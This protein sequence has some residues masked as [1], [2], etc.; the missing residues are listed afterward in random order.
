MRKLLMCLGLLA[1][2]APALAQRSTIQIENPWSRATPGQS[3]TGAAY[4][5]LHNTGAAPDKL[6]SA[7]SPVAAKVELHNHVMSGNVAQMRPVDAIE[8]A[9]GSPTVLQPGGLHVMLIDLKEP[10]KAGQKFPVTLTFEKAGAISVEVAVQALRP[11]PSHSHGAD[12]AKP[13]H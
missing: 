5:T 12:P 10:L 1:F 2:A 8:V 4:L 13:A 9:P 7:A 11:E 3:K 6:L